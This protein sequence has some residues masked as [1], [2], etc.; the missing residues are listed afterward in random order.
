MQTLKI[1]LK[2]ITSGILEDRLARFLFQYRLTPHSTTGTSPAELLMGRKP[3]STL[4]LLKPNIADRVC[5]NQ[6][7]Q[8]AV[9]DK[10]TAQRTFEIGSPVFVKNF[11]SGPTWL[12][13]NVTSTEGHYSYIIKLSDGRA[14]RRHGDHIRNRSTTVDET[15]DTDDPLMDPVVPSTQTD[16]LS[17]ETNDSPPV[18]RR[19]TRNR[20]PPD[21][22]TS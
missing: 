20:R 7:K 11:A 5:H 4:D 22:F 8:K 13:G 14:V 19:S 9:H 3:C 21:R 10:G 1:G 15:A 17:Q 18:L 12:A 6:Q 2:K 16:E